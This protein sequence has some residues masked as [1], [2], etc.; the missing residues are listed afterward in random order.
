MIIF[1]YKNHTTK[2]NESRKCICLR[3]NIVFIRH[4]AI[5]LAV[6]GHVVGVDLGSGDAPYHSECRAG[7]S[8]AR[9]RNTPPACHK[10]KH[11]QWSAHW[12]LT[13]SV[14]LHKVNHW[15]VTNKSCL[16]RA[17]ERASGLYSRLWTDSNPT[18]RPCDST[19]S[20]ADTCAGGR[21]RWLTLRQRRPS[22]AARQPN[23]DNIHE[24]RWNDK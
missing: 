17:D 5:G 13:W 23:M 4:R 16:S 21:D 8:A 1:W 15:A 7:S 11:A 10:Q 24:H 9:P 22:T 3:L 6:A 19:S 20:P 18:S 14:I 12:S 2:L